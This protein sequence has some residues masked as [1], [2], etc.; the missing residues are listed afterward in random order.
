[1]RISI[2]SILLSL[3]FVLSHATFAASLNSSA[4]IQEGLRPF[5]SDPQFQAMIAPV[6]LRAGSVF[7]NEFGNGSYVENYDPG[8]TL[9]QLKTTASNILGTRAGQS[10]SPLYQ[11]ALICCSSSPSCER[12]LGDKLSAAAR[13]ALKDSSAAGL[14]QAQQNPDAAKQ[15]LDSTARQSEVSLQIQQ[16]VIGACVVR[17]KHCEFR[18]RVV[19]DKL[20]ADAGCAQDASCKDLVTKLGALNGQCKGL[21]PSSAIAKAKSIQSTTTTAQ[22][23]SDQLKESSVD[24]TTASGAPGGGGGLDPG[25]VGALMNG[26][27]AGLNTQKPELDTTTMQQQGMD[28][29]S[30]PNIAGCVK[31]D[32]GRFNTGFENS[33][34][35]SS[36]P[37]GGFNPTDVR[38]DLTADDAS[39]QSPITPTAATNPGIP[40]NGGGG[41]PNSQAAAGGGGA[42]AASGGGSNAPTGRA[43]ILHGVGSVNG[44]SQTNAGMNMAPS[45]SGGFGG[46]GRAE[47]PQGVELAQF[48][49][50]GAKDPSRMPAGL[51]VNVRG[52]VNGAQVDIWNRISDRVRARCSQGL[53]RDCI[54]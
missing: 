44:Y 18:T 41:I 37:Q 10:S 30:N 36:S 20:N 5:S 34:M 52:Q 26:L 45:S 51:A 27:S 35:N 24:D 53:L 4:A 19:K 46:Y 13:N 39:A 15:S 1:M 7:A 11:N 49:P 40:N 14:A 9:Q 22:E 54:P 43:D 16:S 8:T 32:P 6:S 31:E 17:A 50:G 3:V 33:T 12:S 29:D 47:E 48:L 28:C 21:N 42:P 38:P 25:M 23:G 2:Q